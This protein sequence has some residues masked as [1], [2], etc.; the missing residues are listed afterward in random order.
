[1]TQIMYVGNGKCDVYVDGS[2]V[3]TIRM[4]GL[5]CDWPP[6]AEEDKAD[7]VGYGAGPMLGYPDYEN[8]DANAA[9]PIVSAWG[10]RA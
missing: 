9:F 6:R 10:A 2:L 4:N 1:M 8:A 5:K 3:D 7:A